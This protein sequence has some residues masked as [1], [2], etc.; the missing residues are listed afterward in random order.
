MTL[1]VKAMAANYAGLQVTGHNI[2]NANVKGF[3]RQEVSLVATEGQFSGAGYFGRGVDVSSVMRAHNAHLTREAAGGRSVAAMDA[4]RLSQLRRLENVFKPGEEGLGHASTQLMTALGD[5]ASR[6][7]DLASRQVVLA[8]ADELATRFNAAASQFEEAQAGIFGELKSAVD[9]V[10]G[11]TQNLAVLNQRIAAAQATGQP[12]NDLLDE[13]ERLIGR[14]SEQIKVTR[15]EAQDGSVGIFAAGGQRLVL[16]S[17]AARLQLLQDPRDSTRSAVGVIEFGVQRTLGEGAMG[18]GAMAGLLRF[19]NDDLVNARNLVGR[20]AAALGGAINDQQLRGL[21]LQTPVG[22]VPSA[23]LFGFGPSAAVPHSNNARDSSGAYVGSVNLTLT[24]PGDLQ[25]SEYELAEDAANPGSYLLKRLVDGRTQPVASGDTVD[26]MR[27]DFGTPPP[28]GGDRYLLQPVARVASGMS[29]LLN[30]PRDLAAASVQIA[31]VGQANFGTGN[32]GALKI[33]A[34]PLP[35]PGATTNI[36]FTSDTGDYD[37][38]LLDAGNAVVGSG[39]GVWSSSKTIPAAPLDINGFT[40]L[41]SGNPRSGDT[42]TVRPTPANA[43]QSNNGNALEL[44]NVGDA[45]VVGGRTPTD[46]WS[47]ML[48]DIGVRVQ[49]GKTASGIS[50]AVAAQSEALRSAQAGVNLDEEAARLI[51]YQQSY[52]AAAKVLQVAQA[53]FDTLLE[54]TGR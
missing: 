51:Q 15:I 53:L 9:Q 17:E 52:Q 1:G 2:A 40:L 7:S 37:W 42:L 36:T 45:N 32:I 10:N 34:A 50:D 18:G 12:P 6:P 54:M 39:S 19:Q 48:S 23:P 24:T 26:G 5:L 27:I 8:R 31:S 41:I 47:L 28:Q 33:T 22:Q 29:R 11:L 3:S 30:D 25:A 13:R 46:A 4:A 35:V 16:G 38:Q 43:L 44:M 14:I 20:M 49:S 21:N